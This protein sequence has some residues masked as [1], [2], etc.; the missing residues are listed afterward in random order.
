MRIFGDI[1]GNHSRCVDHC[2]ESTGKRTVS[3]IIIVEMVAF[4][5]HSADK[6]IRVRTV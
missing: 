1:P 6:R 5:S 4:A 3:E 2:G